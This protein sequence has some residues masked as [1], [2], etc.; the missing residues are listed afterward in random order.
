MREHDDEETPVCALCG[1]RIGT[2]KDAMLMMRGQF[3]HNKQ[4]GYPMFL[5]DPDTKYSSLE[6]DNALG[7]GQHQQG[8]LV[9]PN[10][11]Y[12]I[13]PAHV[14]CLRDQLTMIDDDDDDDDEV[15][16]E[17]R[18][19]MGRDFNPLW[20]DDDVAVHKHARRHG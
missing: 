10:D 1:E 11:T 20:D 16:L 4:D 14:D 2:M 3:F 17:M 5:L 15:D 7:P 12:P 8:L 6:L 9:D 19:A 18:D 13:I